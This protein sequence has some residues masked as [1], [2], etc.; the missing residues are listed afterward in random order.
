[1]YC[2][3]CG[4]RIPDE[5]CFCGK[6]GKPVNGSSGLK[7]QG[8][9]LNAPR[10]FPFALILTV[11]LSML[12][13]ERI[14]DYLLFD[15]TIPALS[16]IPSLVML[17]ALI[18]LCATG[19]IAPAKIRANALFFP[20]SMFLLGLV[21]I[22]FCATLAL[23]IPQYISTNPNIL[24]IIRMTG[25]ELY[26]GT[27]PAWQWGILILFL[28]LRS[29]TLRLRKTSFAIL[30]VFVTTILAAWSV[31]LICIYPRN[32]WIIDDSLIWTVYSIHFSSLW[33]R[34]L[35]I[36]CFVLL[37]GSGR[38]SALSTML[39]PVVIGMFTFS[40]LMFAVIFMRHIYAASYAL[41]AGYLIGLLFLAISC[42]SRTRVH[43]GP[44]T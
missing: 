18:T 43:D 1:M 5:S 22:F 37:A 3:Y 38:L 32:T 19:L 21:K 29:G 27:G 17:G 13:S 36:Y 39:F 35:V 30:T 8:G 25:I 23:L 40:L 12:F 44:N 4:Q 26:W 14:L 34:N 20:G 33:I 7:G 2:N 11:F 10:Q 41:T 16:L 9:S 42:L 31:F 24:F 6:C 28:L 15:N